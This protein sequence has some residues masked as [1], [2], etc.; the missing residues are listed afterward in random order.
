MP[1]PDPTQAVYVWPDPPPGRPG[2]DWVTFRRRFDLT[3]APAAAVLHLFATHRYRLSLDGDVVGYG[4]ARYV[5]G[6]EWHDTYGLRERLGPGPHD[7][8]VEACFIDANN[9]QH[10]PEPRGRFLAW[11]HIDTAGG[12]PIDLA[13]PGEWACRRPPQ[14]YP[15]APPFSFA[16]GP[17][18]VVD[19]RLAA[20]GGDDAAWSIPPP[21]PDGDG[22]MPTPR[23]TPYPTG[24]IIIPTPVLLAD[25]AEDERRVGYLSVAPSDAPG[26]PP[27]RDTV[28]ALRSRYAVCLHSPRDQTVTLALHWGPHFL[29][30]EPLHPTD[31]P[32]HGN[33]QAVEVTLHEGWNLL[34]GEPAQLQARYPVLLGWPRDAALTARSRPDPDD[35]ATLRYTPPRAVPDDESWTRRAPATPADL[36]DAP[37]WLTVPRDAPLAL[38]AREMSWDRIAPGTATDKPRLPVTRRADGPPFTLILDFGTEYLGHVRVTLDAPA[39][40]VLDLGYDERRRADGCLDFFATNPYVDAADRFVTAAGRTTLETFNPRGGRYLQLT[41]RPPRDAPPDATITLHAV[42]LRDARCLPVYDRP[43]PAVVDTDPLFAWAWHTGAATLRASTE[44]AYCD[45]PWR[46]RGLYLGD[47]YVQSRV[48]LLLTTD[49]ANARRAL[50]LFAAG[51]FDDGQLPCVVPSWLG[52]PHGDFTLIYP[53]WLHDFYA[54]TGDASI[55]REALPAV[56]RLLASPTWQTSTHSILWDATEANRLFIDW[57]VLQDARRYDENATLNAFRVRALQC[58]A[59]LHDAAGDPAAADRYRAAADRVADAFRAR[60]WLDGHG[61][62]AGGTADGHPVTRDVLHPNLLALAFG[63]APPE[64]EPRLAAYVLQRL[65]HNAE[66]AARGVPHDD[67]AELY[68]LTFAFQALHRLGRRDAADRL[69]RDHMSIM[70]DHAAPTLWECLHRGVRGRGSLCHAWSAAPLLHLAA[71]TPA[72]ST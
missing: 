11:G 4:P 72:A 7:L 14:R 38:P 10:A 15:E 59:S 21:L 54:A 8:T 64:Q 32:G 29:N 18:E 52:L 68:F 67:F 12:P 23:L 27:D 5:P 35:P 36:P 28:K 2:L 49:T 39:G 63:L 65:E 62:F 19:Q 22:A 16:I 37:K 70:R 34:C 24:E 42:D 69:L 20:T 57:G 46:E 50:Q 51:Q 13:T 31:V 6:T 44:D 58:A 25:L 43:T 40:T 3:A 71:P 48:E 1:E 26:V 33:R 60:L 56:D 61:R 47:S 41:V 30:G 55:V 9:F 66:H 53:V 17:V 45:S